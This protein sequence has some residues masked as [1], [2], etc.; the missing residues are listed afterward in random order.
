MVTG[1]N[2]G[3]GK[4]TAVKLAGMGATVIL[5]CR[6]RAKGERAM[7]DIK[8]KGH[9]DAVE[10][11]FADFTSLASIR[12]LTREF[13]EGHDSLN[14]LVNNAGGARLGR[15][16]TI[17]GFET[18]FQVNYLSHFLLTNLL[19]EELKKGAPSRVVNVSSEAHYGGHLDF[20]DLQMEKNYG[21]MKA[22]GQAKLAL[23]LFTYELARRLG[24][25]GVTVNC[26]HPGVVATNIWGNAMG[27]FA[28][29]G[30]ISRLFMISPER[31]AETSVYLA[32]SPEVE[33]VTGKYF[34]RKQ[35]KRSSADSYD[36]AL[37][38]R[39]W[40]TSAALVGLGEASPEP[41]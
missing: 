24:E 34:E 31:G 9:S 26:L 17:D 5:V 21:V 8:E 12:G 23:V 25:T 30:K 1:A 18:N 35:E 14:V 7:A 38:E 29:L 16:V 4:E 22:Y 15:S 41:S 32:S 10:L 19:L 6:N 2:S 27:P 11:L 40:D 37:A 39:L 33:G 28:F 13:E 3:I 20:G 36:R